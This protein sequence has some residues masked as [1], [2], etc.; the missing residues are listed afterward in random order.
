M[1]DDKNPDTREWA[2]ITEP[3]PRPAPAPTGPP[4]GADDYRP[5]DPLI[6]EQD[7]PAR[8]AIPAQ[9]H[10]PGSF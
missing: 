3:A 5:A 9:T 6:R 1:P 7:A 10:H 8:G 2:T 4:A